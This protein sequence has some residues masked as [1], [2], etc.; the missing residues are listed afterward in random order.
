MLILSLPLAIFR[1]QINDCLNLVIAL[2]LWQ[3]ELVDEPIFSDHDSLLINNVV[4]FTIVFL[5][6]VIFVVFFILV[7]FL[8]KISSTL[9]TLHVVFAFLD[10]AISLEH[11]RLAFAFFLAMLVVQLFKDVLDLSLELIINLVHKVLQDFWHAKL[12]GLLAKLLS[13]EN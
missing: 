12:L 3:Y 5:K 4:E 13:C 6:D 1:V 9:K 2:I 7:I 8:V 11:I 10:F